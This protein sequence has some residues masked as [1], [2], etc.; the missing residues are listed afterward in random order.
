M[1]NNKTFYEIML[2]INFHDLLFNH[3]K[4]FKF[5]EF[6][7]FELSLKFELTSIQ[8]LINIKGTFLNSSY[9]NWLL[10]PGV[11][12]G[13]IKTSFKRKIKQQ[14]NCS[15]KFSLQF[16]SKKPCYLSSR[17]CKDEGNRRCWLFLYPFD[18]FLTLIFIVL[19]PFFRWKW[20]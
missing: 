19:F 5:S 14:L 20:V 10:A 4:L 15:Y 13:K 16:T 1:V 18:S 3:D 2:I 6:N 11:N 12:F 17:I 8:N 9:L 7:L